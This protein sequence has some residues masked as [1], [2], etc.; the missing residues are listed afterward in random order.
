LV[1]AVCRRVLRMRDDHVYDLSDH[2]GDR[3]ISVIMTVIVLNFHHRSPD[4]Y[5]MPPWV[6]TAHRL[7]RPSLA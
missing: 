7:Y 1:V 2:D 3:T 6:S 5:D 4:M